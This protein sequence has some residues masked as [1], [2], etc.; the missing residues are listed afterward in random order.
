L[1]S[2]T[3]TEAGGQSTLSIRTL[4]GGCQWSV[5]LPEWISTTAATS[6]A[7]ST[8]LP[9]TIARSGNDRTGT[10][11]VSR[12]EREV[13]QQARIKLTATCFSGRPGDV[14]LLACTA[15]IEH[16][17][18]PVVPIGRPSADFSPMG[19]GNEVYGPYTAGNYDWDLHIP[20]DQP[21]GEITI[22]IRVPYGDGFVAT[23]A[24]QFS[25]LPPR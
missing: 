22:P 1:S 16:R 17:P 21:V 20:A 8:D 3:F 9:L 4:L 5:T 14:V 11:V 12:V 15:I 24:P 25:V 7:G 23:A 2:A 19:K 13:R 10:I 18:G 6:G